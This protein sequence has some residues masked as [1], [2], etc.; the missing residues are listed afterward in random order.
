MALNKREMGKSAVEEHHAGDKSVR[1]WTV[2]E[3]GISEIV[4]LPLVIRKLGVILV[5]PSRRRD[6]N[7]EDY[8]SILMKG[9]EPSRNNHLNIDWGAHVAVLGTLRNDSSFHGK[10]TD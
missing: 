7:F 5:W 4:G 8:V 9:L 10:V 6:K 3:L 1:C 2:I